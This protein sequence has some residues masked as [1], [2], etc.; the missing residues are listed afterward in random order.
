[1]HQ[2]LALAIHHRTHPNPRVGAVILDQGGTLIAQG[3]HRGPGLPHAEQEALSA[4]GGGVPPGA[5]LVVTLEPCNHHGRT[6]PCTEALLAAGISRVVVGAADPDSRVAGSGVA[7]LVAAG[8]EVESGVLAE[9]IEAADRAYFH[10]RRHNRP[11]ITLK[12]A[13]TVDGQ[14]AALDG[15]SQWITSPAA[16]LDAHRLRS[17]A[18]AV[19]IGA[20]TL[21]ADDPLLTVRLDDY[22]GPQPTAVVV[23][24]NGDL[25][26]DAR[27][28]SRREVLVLAARPLDLPV[29]TAVV[30]P[31]PDGL[32]APIA[33][34]HTLGDRGLLSVLIEG[35]AT[36]AGSLWRAG[37]VDAGVTYVGAKV[38][39]GAGM[40]PFGG[41]WRTLSEATSVVIEGARPIG[42][43]VRIDWR[44][45]RQP[46]Q[47]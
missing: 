8:I 33:I 20:G 34:A 25:P 39:G 22:H 46:I 13:T 9:E 44:I 40:P 14:T 28:W 24:G 47:E 42:E 18:D 16:R 27:L 17:E 19:V 30:E 43:D 23:S 38:A 6:P 37:L 11:L 21:R 45:S 2:A 31:G 35:G 7:R 32:P 1:M 36:L 3:A 5:T 10:H 41:R 4:L 26:D 12:M 15:T 29:E